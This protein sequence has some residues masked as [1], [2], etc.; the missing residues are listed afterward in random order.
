[1]KTFSV[2]VWPCKEMEDLGVYELEVDCNWWVLTRRVHIDNLEQ[3]IAESVRACLN[4][5]DFMP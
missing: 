4:S 1:M 5:E 3:Q 2:T